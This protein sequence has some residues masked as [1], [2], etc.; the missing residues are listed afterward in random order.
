MKGNKHYRT[1][2]MKKFFAHCAALM[3]AFAVLP[4]TAMNHNLLGPWWNP[5]QCSLS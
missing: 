4:T 3:L 5:P 2:S 1:S